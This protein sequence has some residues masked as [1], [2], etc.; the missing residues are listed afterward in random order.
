MPENKR[1]APQRLNEDPISFGFSNEPFRKTEYGA[2]T[3]S[4]HGSCPLAMS[5]RGNIIVGL[6]VLFPPSPRI[7][8][9]GDA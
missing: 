7:S 5:F 6:L 9:G 3:H 2:M 1:C 4:P 8:L